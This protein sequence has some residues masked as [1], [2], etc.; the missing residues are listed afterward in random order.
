MRRPGKVLPI[1]LLM[2][3]FLSAKP[4]AALADICAI[5]GKPIEGTI[6]LM[7][8]EVTG[9]KV[10]VCSDCIKL[11]R[12]AICGLPVK[13]NYTELPDG[14]YFC[15][16][17]AK[18]LVIKPD[19]AERV[20]AEVKDDLD[21][22]FSRFTSFPDNVDVTAIDRID[23]DSLFHRMGNDF[24]SP[25]LLGCIQ[26]QT[27][28]G[29][30]RYQMSLMTGLPLAELKETCAHEY[31]HAWVGENVDR[32]PRGLGRDAE[33][34]FCEMVGYL[35]MESQSETGEE[36]R[37]LEN[38]YTRGQVDL[39]IEAERRYGFDQ[40]LDWMK[41]GTTAQLEAGHLDE[42]RDVKMTAAK[43]FTPAINI[44]TENKMIK[45]SP[46]PATIQLQGIFWGSNPT[47]IINGHSFAVNDLSKVKIGG[48]NV[49]IRCLSIEPKQVV[50]QNV[51]SGQ[52]QKLQMSSQ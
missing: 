47:A 7:T 19:D 4:L 34:G 40:I 18:T 20:C 35:L 46:A 22:L 41:Y 17:D 25:N 2:V 33:E 52:E 10:L 50:I 32:A 14:R 48:T 16:R 6:Y 42:I 29:K 11:P 15:A 9:E 24:E 44:V 37:V 39:F 5:C 12:C 8:D 36:K 49:S 38:R 45:P 51:D 31:S 23:V 28:N 27:V 13:E 43:T 3:C 1:F 26:P 21:R 30:K